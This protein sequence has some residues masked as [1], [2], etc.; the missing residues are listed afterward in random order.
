[1]ANRPSAAPSNYVHCG[2]THPVKTDADSLLPL[3]PTTFHIL[4]AVA[5]ADR[6]I[7]PAESRLLAQML[8][9]AGARGLAPR[10]V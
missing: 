5:D 6:R 10:K 3:P 7:A 4:V 8:D 1:M 9:L 2:Y